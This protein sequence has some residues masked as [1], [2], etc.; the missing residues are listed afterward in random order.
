[1]GYDTPE[2]AT[3][4]ATYLPFGAEDLH[5]AYY[6]TV[7][8]V[9]A[10]GYFWVFFDSVRHY[11][12]TG[13]QRQLWGTA[14]DISADGRY[15]R[16]PSHPAFYVSGQEFGTGNHRAFAA[17]DPCRKDGDKCTSGIDCCGGYCTIMQAAE[18][19][20]PVGTCSPMKIMCAKRDERCT[21]T[22]D[23]CPAIGPDEPL[24]CIAG[25]CAVVTPPQ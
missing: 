9:G 4:N 2:D 13:L 18:L 25:F 21:T 14:L 23:C 3:K 20:E 12:G 8:P 22:A 11:G 17:L 10:G 5:H 15:I 16:D 19:V 1:M 24:V 7:S 6:P